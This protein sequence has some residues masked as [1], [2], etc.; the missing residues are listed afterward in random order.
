[1]SGVILGILFNKFVIKYFSDNKR[2]LFCILTMLIFIFSSIS[3]AITFGIRSG[4][5]SSINNYS[6]RVEKFIFD[7]NPNNEFLINGINLNIINDNTSIINDSVNELKALIPTHTDL[8]IN[9]R[10]YDM[11]IGYPMGELINQIDVFNNSVSSHARNLTDSIAIITDNNN[12]ITVSS[13]LNYLKSLANRHI[14]IVFF[15]IIIVLLIPFLAYVISISVYV[16]ISVRK[17]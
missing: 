8:R 4:I 10:I 14:N 7:N 15:R 1:V 9:K 16:I 11:V 12:F 2:K 13:I 6:D 3:L 5:I 17:K